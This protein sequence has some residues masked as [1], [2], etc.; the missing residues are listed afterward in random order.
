MSA[1]DQRE[2]IETDDDA[3]ALLEHVGEDHL[4]KSRWPQLLSELV[5]AAA[6]ALS[7]SHPDDPEKAETEARQVVLAIADYLGGQQVYIPRGA[8]VRT[9]V[10]DTMMWREFERGISP[11]RLAKKHQISERQVFNILAAQKAIHLARN[12]GSLFDSTN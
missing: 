1:A 8:L 6:E 4:P 2:L 11:R 12:Q 7:R 3:R 9:A 10:R 5:D